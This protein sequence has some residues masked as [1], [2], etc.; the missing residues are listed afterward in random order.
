MFIASSNFGKLSWILRKRFPKIKICVLFN[1]I[2]FNFILSQISCGF[3][4]QLLLTL[5]ATYLSEL[6][7]VKSAN[8]VIV[9]NDREKNALRRIYG[10]LSDAV[11]PIVLRDEYAE[12][13][14]VGDVR[15]IDKVRIG[16][17]VGSNFYAN[18][19]AV[20]WFAKNV[21]PFT[22]DVYYEIVGKGFEN[23]K[24][25]ECENFKIVGTVDNLKDYYEKADFIIAPIF[26]GA[27]M[28]V[29]VAEAMMYGKTI[30]GTPE[31]FEG[32]TDV[33]RW[34][35]VCTNAREFIDT[36]NEGT[37]ITGF[38]VNARAYFLKLYEY[39]AVKNKLI[40]TFKDENEE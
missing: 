10:R 38:N 39:K 26:K 8:K 22:P 33:L 4:P 2:E 11:I 29:K 7:V 23:E 31:A 28:K 5:C 34:G 20:K 16:V 24:F 3:R 18:N 35:K 15:G 30:I 14:N 1:N 21:A 13:Q 19:H 37:F 40:N 9:L 12:Y 25:L 32:Y 36:I 27:G 17:F 6:K